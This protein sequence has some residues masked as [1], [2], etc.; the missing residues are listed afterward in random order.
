MVALVM[1]RGNW[2]ESSDS[3]PAK[4]FIIHIHCISVVIKVWKIHAC[5]IKDGIVIKSFDLI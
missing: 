1:V 5:R 4:T 2:S 3:P